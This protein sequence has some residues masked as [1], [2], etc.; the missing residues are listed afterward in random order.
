MGEL[1]KLT[2]IGKEVKR[3]LNKVGIIN[4]TPVILGRTIIDNKK[5]F[6]LKKDWATLGVDTTNTNAALGSVNK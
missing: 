4:Y 2:N 3:Q 5:I 6:K 1:A